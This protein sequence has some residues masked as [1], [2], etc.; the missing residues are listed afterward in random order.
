LK[1][2]EYQLK[3]VLGT[4]LSQYESNDLQESRQLIKGNSIMNYS[5]VRICLYLL[6]A[7]KMEEWNVGSKGGNKPF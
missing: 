5:L 7:I 6:V 2:S 1:F 3:Q 4:A